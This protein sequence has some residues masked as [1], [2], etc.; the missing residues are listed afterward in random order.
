VR[1]IAAAATAA[2][3]LLLGAAASA[4][5]EAAT[6]V[7]TNGWIE[8][9]AFE[10]SIA[11]FDVEAVGMRCNRLFIWRITS[12]A[13]M[14]VGGRRTCAAD[15]TSTGRGVTAIALT[16]TRAAWVVN[17]GGNT[18]SVD[19]LL[20]SPLAGP[21]ET[22]VAEVVRRGSVDAALAGGW[23]GGLV[24]DGATI[25]FNHW[26]TAL[27]EDG[28]EVI[29]SGSLR[30]L[31]GTATRELAS[32]TETQVAQS[33]DGGRIAVLR[34]D[35]SVALHGANGRLL[36]VVVPTARATAATLSGGR[37]ALVTTRRTIEIRDAASGG[38]V[39]AWRAAGAVTTRVDLEGRLLAYG[40]GRRVHVLDVVSGRT[41]AVATHTRAIVDVQIEPSGVLYAYNTV[42]GTKPVGNVVFVPARAVR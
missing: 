34:A 20:T 9:L 23:L 5:R 3:L 28:R 16:G 39:A 21:R 25:V 6:T 7:R 17:R 8:A 29:R 4:G 41:R 14:Q 2:V 1:T 10:G 31:A 18:E 40:A 33:V 42:S 26:R 13:R 24:S 37:L 32:G 35:G 15:E 27:D 11:A 38:V 12:G 19:T 30:R 36:R 22:R